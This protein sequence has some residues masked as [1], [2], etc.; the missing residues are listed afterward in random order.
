MVAVPPARRLH[1]RVSGRFVQVA[2]SS[3][4]TSPG[5]PTCDRL[6]GPLSDTAHDIHKKRP[7]NLSGVRPLPALLTGPGVVWAVLGPEHGGRLC[8]VSPGLLGA[9]PSS[10][11]GPSGHVAG[12]SGSHGLRGAWG[13]EGGSR[14]TSSRRHPTSYR[15][16]RSGVRPATVGREAVPLDDGTT[17]SRQRASHGGARASEQRC[18]LVTR[19]PFEDP[20]A[21]LRAAVAG[22]LRRQA[23]RGGEG[24]GGLQARRAPAPE[25]S[26]LAHSPASAEWQGASSRLGPRSPQC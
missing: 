20:Q 3:S 18:G 15:Q 6:P 25:G 4:P 22:T 13:S 14:C 17:V 2:L 16:S 1:P 23:L 24:P 19:L 10:L 7:R 21:R 11:S 5:K 8:P 26:E 12:P 9:L